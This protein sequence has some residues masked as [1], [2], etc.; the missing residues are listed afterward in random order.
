M[1]DKLP[2]NIMLMNEHLHKKLLEEPELK[3]NPKLSSKIEIVCDNYKLVIKD[4]L[5]IINN[6]KDNKKNLWD[7]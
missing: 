3:N 5:A 1:P 7:E 2:R 4:L 6:L